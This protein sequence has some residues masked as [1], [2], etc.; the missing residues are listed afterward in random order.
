MR[1]RNRARS[2]PFLSSCRMTGLNLGVAA[3]NSFKGVAIATATAKGF[4]HEEDVARCKQRGEHAN[5]GSPC[6]SA[7]AL[8]REGDLSMSRTLHTGLA[9]F[10]TVVLLTTA[11]PQP[12]AAHIPCNGDFQVTKYGLI[13][14]PYCGEEQ[15]AKV[16]NSYGWRYS[17][18]EVHNNALTKVYLCQTIGYDWRLQAACS[19]YS[20]H[21]GGHR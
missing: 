7:P 18:A 17:A 20:P 9:S 12:A 15:I 11:S 6:R 5:N 14:T 2:T 1:M 19:G 3:R 16:A 13:A 21:G 8:H 4:I 10:A